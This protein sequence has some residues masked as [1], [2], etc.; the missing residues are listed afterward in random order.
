[1]DT[2]QVKKK[3]IKLVKVGMIF[4]II[5]LLMVISAIVIEFTIEN[6]T[7]YMLLT[8]QLGGIGLILSG[9]F[10]ALVAVV[11]VLDMI[12]DKQVI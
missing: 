7:G 12:P 6:S 8:L 11:S 2:E 3:I 5:G 9:I 4:W 10:L 1:M